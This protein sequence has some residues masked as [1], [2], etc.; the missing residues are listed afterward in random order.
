MIRV[1]LPASSGRKIDGSRLRDD[2]PFFTPINEI[3]FFAWA[4]GEVGWF[5]PYGK[6]RGGEVKRQLIRAAIA[7]E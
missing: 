6:N 1:R 4:A 5:Y 7:A 3:S 2:V